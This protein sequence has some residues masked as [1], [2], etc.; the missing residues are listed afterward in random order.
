MMAIAKK[1]EDEAAA[2]L[3]ATEDAALAYRKRMEQE[4][5]A[6]AAAELKAKQETERL[7]AEKIE[8]AK[9]AAKAP[10][11][12]KLISWITKLE[13]P[14]PEMRNDAAKATA[15]DITAKFEGFKRWANQQIEKL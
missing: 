13:A 15:A 4:Q 10:D 6:K 3:K 14:M 12:V 8:A 2:T 11:K 5:E 7:E 1:N 9:I